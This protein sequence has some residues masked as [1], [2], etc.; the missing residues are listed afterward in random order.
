MRAFVPTTPLASRGCGTLLRN[1]LPWNA[2]KASPGIMLDG[3]A[4]AAPAPR[5]VAPVASTEKV[6][7]MTDRFASMRPFTA[8]DVLLSVAFML[9]T[10]MTKGKGSLS[11]LG[12]FGDES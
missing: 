1:Y 3:E 2:S 4:I 10:L 7:D 8:D 11:V 9:L 6:I 12:E 5:N